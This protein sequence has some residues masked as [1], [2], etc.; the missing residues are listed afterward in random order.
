MI[1]DFEKL[2]L[3]VNVKSVSSFAASGDETA[4]DK[5]T[6]HLYMWGN[7]ARPGRL[8][9]Q[10]FMRI[11][12]IDYAGGNGDPNWSNYAD[13]EYTK[14]AI[15]QETAK[16]IEERQQFVNK[17][18][19]IFSKDVGI[20][21]ISSY[22]NAGMARNDAIEMTKLGNKGCHVYNWSM[23]VNSEYL[24]DTVNIA[25]FAA[26]SLNWMTLSASATIGWWS[27]IPNSPL[28]NFDENWD[29]VAILAKDWPT[30]ENDGTKYI[31]ELREGATFHNGDSITAED[32][33]FTFEQ[34]ERHSA[35]Y[36]LLDKMNYSSIDVIDDHTVE[37]NFEEPQ[38]RWLTAL[39]PSAGI[40][41]KGLWENQGA[42]EDPSAFDPG[43]ENFVGS[44]PYQVVG[45]E[46]GRRVQFAPYED[47]VYHPTPQANLVKHE[48]ASGEARAVGFLD[49]RFDMMWQMGAP[50]I[51]RIEASMDSDQYNLVTT[52]PFTRR[53]MHPQMQYGPTKF[54]EFRDA[55]SKALNR[56]KAIQVAFQGLAEP[57]MTPTPFG[58]THPFQPPQEFLYSTTDDPQGD[59]DAAKQTL[60][61]EGWTQ[62]DNG[63]WRYPADADLSPL[64]PQGE[65]PSPD[66]F[67]C[68]N[69]L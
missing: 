29:R 28:I 8:D 66:D 18:Q 63:N 53:F 12:S 9:P 19:E 33:K 34:I 41:H 6:A 65:T 2:G 48:V 59:I 43:V 68:L 20:I 50:S 40:L 57:A 30:I 58:D 36:P 22:W 44:G 51:R 35:S 15:A 52:T 14:Y 67:P 39:A 10:E 38:P 31:V 25:Y 16:S 24:K 26:E 47:H 3:D 64:W 37:F 4:N 11:Y 69:S 54:R 17:G 23:L 60:K 56:E 55:L 32:V 13:C 62:D 45:F 27:T 49:G 21:P 42:D 1:E 7:G 46:P 5:R 61:D